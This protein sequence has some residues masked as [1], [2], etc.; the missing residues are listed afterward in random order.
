M[1]IYEERYGD[2]ER[3]EHLSRLR[4]LLGLVELIKVIKMYSSPSQY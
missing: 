3:V 2:D 1:E 4:F